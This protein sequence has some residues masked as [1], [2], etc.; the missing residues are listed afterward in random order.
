V[1]FEAFDGKQIG[2]TD[3]FGSYAKT[4]DT[5]IKVLV[6]DPCAQGQTVYGPYSGLPTTCNYTPVVPGTYKVYTT[7]WGKKSNVMTFTVTGQ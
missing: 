4:Q 1:T 6:K 2:L 5:L 3:T 7:P